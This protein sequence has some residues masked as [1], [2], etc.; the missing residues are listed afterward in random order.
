MTKEEFIE[1]GFYKIA[2]LCDRLL[3]NIYQ[4]GINKEYLLRFCKT[5]KDGLELIEETLRDKDDKQ[6]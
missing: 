1:I 5:M 3:T 4:H 6:R 2:L